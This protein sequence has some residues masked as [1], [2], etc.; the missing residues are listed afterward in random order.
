MKKVLMKMYSRDGKKTL[1]TEQQ[2]YPKKIT[3]I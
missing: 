2:H 1:G 3:G